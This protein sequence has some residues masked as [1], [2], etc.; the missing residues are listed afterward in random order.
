MPVNARSRLI[1]TLAAI[2]AVAAHGWLSPAGSALAWATPTALFAGALGAALWRRGAQA[3]IFATG[4]VWPLLTFLAAGHADPNAL[5]VWLA[6]VLGIAVASAPVGRWSLPDSWRTPVAAWGVILAL[7][8]PIVLWRELDFS[9]VAYLQNDTING[10]LGSSPRQTAAFVTS[11]TLAQLC[12]IVVF[13]W[14]WAR[15]GRRDDTAFVREVVWPMTIGTVIAIA[16]GLRQGFVDIAWLSAEPWP[17]LGRAGGGFFDANAFGAVAA[18]WGSLVAGAM[19]VSGRRWPAAAGLALLAASAAA[20]WLS[21]SRTAMVSCLLV[22]AGLAAT[23][24]FTGR[25][26]RRAVGAAAV[27]LAVL[28]AVGAERGGPGTAIQRLWQTM[29]TPTAAGLASFATDMWERNGYGIAAVQMVR[30]FPAA[31]VGPGAYPVLAPDYSYVT[32]GTLIPGD[33]AQNWWRQQLTE[34]GVLGSVAPLVCSLLVAA[35][36][37]TLVRRRSR[38]PMAGLAAAAMIAL[39]VMALVGPPTAH[40]IVLQTTTVMLFWASRFAFAGAPLDAA[41]PDTKRQ[42]TAAASTRERSKTLVLLLVVVLPIVWAGLTLRN[43]FTELR[44]PFRAQRVGWRY[45][46]GFSAA[47]PVSDGER[48]WVAARAVGVL[49]AAGRRLMLKLEPPAWASESDPVRIRVR[50]RHRLVLDTTQKTSDAFWCELDVLPGDRWVMV[51][52]DTD[53]PATPAVR[54]GRALRVTA[55]WE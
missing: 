29:P 55:R 39:G 19:V 21:G 9:I 52:I 14:L 5:V 17:R 4:H 24:V 22:D 30:D 1:V 10:L 32:T 20:V 37:V 13:D 35:M 15:Y 7:G 51:Q 31:G 18:L 50:D 28:I 53:G 25:V 46:Y 40:P 6:L 36:V 48:R 47:E 45:G 34:L 41:L 2:A 12:A 44:P 38:D 42:K 3:A 27:G 26:S 8:W 54:Q 43:A 23:L 16:V 33:N 11:A 49:P